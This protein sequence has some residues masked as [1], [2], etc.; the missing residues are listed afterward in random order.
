DGAAQLNSTKTKRMIAEA[1]F[2]LLDQKNIDTITVKYLVDYCGVSRQTFYYH[3]RDILDVVEW[4]LGQLVEQALQESLQAKDRRDA[5]SIFVS[6]I[7]AGK[8]SIHRI[9][10]SQHRAEFEQILSD[11]VSTYLRALLHFGHPAIRLS[12]ADFP[13]LLDFCT[14]GIVGLI[15]KQCDQ[16]D[17]DVDQLVDHLDRLLAALILPDTQPDGFMQ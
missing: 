17:T 10:S 11:A 2:E 4:G 6:R 14:Y 12:A 5:V 3:F 15:V 7:I 9:L 16:P 13:T 8:S 1:L